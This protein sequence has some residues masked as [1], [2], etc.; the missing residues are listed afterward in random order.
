MIISVINQ[1]GGAGKTTIA[2]NLASGIAKRGAKV[3]LVD[4]DIQGS[5]RDWHSSAQT[6]TIPVVGID[7]AKGLASG[8]ASLASSYQVVIIDGAPTIDEMAI[9]TIKLSDIVLIPVQPSPY[10]IWAANTVVEMVKARQSL[11]NK[12]NSAFIISRSIP[13]TILGREISNALSEYS[14]TIL[15]GTTQRQIYAKAAATGQSVYD[16]S[17]VSAIEEI[18]SI[19]D[20]I[21]SLI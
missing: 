7:R 19:L 11:T 14:M 15:S 1:K 10:D 17:D 13:N 20:Y 12:P 18:D 21:E 16:F 9:E 5:A 3:I 4:T 8:V 6:P 2:T